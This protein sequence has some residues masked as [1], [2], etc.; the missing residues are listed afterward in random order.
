LAKKKSLENAT[1]ERVEENRSYLK[2]EKILRS[3]RSL[4]YVLKSFFKLPKLSPAQSFHVES[5]KVT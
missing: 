5:S 2:F 1:K 3:F 4:R